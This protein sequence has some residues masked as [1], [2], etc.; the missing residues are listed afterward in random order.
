MAMDALSSLLD[1]LLTGR[2]EVVDLTQP[3]SEN[4]PTIQ[5]PPPFANTPGWTM[6][7]ISR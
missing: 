1:A 7:E 3:L 4:T 6:H 2:V 5:L